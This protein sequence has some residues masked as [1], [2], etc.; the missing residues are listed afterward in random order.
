MPDI[1]QVSDISHTSAPTSQS[2]WATI[3]ADVRKDPQFNKK[4]ADAESLSKEFE[5]I[6]DRLDQDGNGHVSTLEIESARNNPAFANDRQLLD[7]LHKDY[8]TI[9]DLVPGTHGQYGITTSDV[10]K[11]PTI[12]DPS[13][14]NNAAILDG[15][16]GATIGAEAGV[17]VGGVSSSG[18]VLLGIAVFPPTLAVAAP[19][20]AGTAAVAAI[21][22][23]AAASYTSY[24]ASVENYNQARAKLYPD[25]P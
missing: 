9:V 8:A 10:E 13:Q 3:A 6:F 20:V 17:F 24:K 12:L 1:H 14:A 19:I 5:S 2:P 18:A 7:F 4:I 11:I 15:V 22:L 23:G 16:V 25:V 21:G